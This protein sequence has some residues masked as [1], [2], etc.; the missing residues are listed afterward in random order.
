MGII[1][2]LRAT[3]PLAGPLAEQSVKDGAYSGAMLLVAVCNGAS[4]FLFR[5][6]KRHASGI[7]WC[8]SAVSLIVSA[9]GMLLHFEIVESLHKATLLLIIPMGYLIATRLCKGGNSE[10]PLGSEHQ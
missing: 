6:Q 9:A 3:S 2:H 8:L 5:D 1:L 4:A 7:Y 10:R